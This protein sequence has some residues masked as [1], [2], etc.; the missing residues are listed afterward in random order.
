MSERV[1]TV[2]FDDMRQIDQINY[3]RQLAKFNMELAETRHELLIAK[4]SQKYSLSDGD[5]INAD[6]SISRKAKTE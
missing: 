5:V 1:E 2:T 6:G 4:L 3:Q